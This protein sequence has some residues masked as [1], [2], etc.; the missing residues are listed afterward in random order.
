MTTIKK[1]IFVAI[2][3]IGIILMIVLFTSSTKKSFEC[4][5]GTFSD[6]GVTKC[7]Y[8]P[9]GKYSSTPKSTT[10]DDCPAGQYSNKGSDTC[11][12]CPAGQYASSSGSPEC[13]QCDAGSISRGGVVF[14]CDDCP[15]GQS[16]NKGSM[17]CTDCPAGKSSINGGLCTDCPAGKY[18]VKAGLCTDCPAGKYASS[19]GS[20]VC[21]NCPAGQYSDKGSNVCTKC[22]KGKYS[23]EG[24]SGCLGCPRGTHG[25]KL[26]A[27]S[28]T[29]GCIKCD[30][31]GYQ[32]ETG[33]PECKM[34]SD[35]GRG[36]TFSHGSDNANDCSTCKRG[37]R[38]V[39]GLCQKCILDGYYSP[40]AGL[41]EKCPKD[42]YSVMDNSF[43]IK[44]TLECIDCPDGW[45]TNGEVGQKYCQE[46][47]KE[48]QTIC[49]P[50]PDGTISLD[51]DQSSSTSIFKPRTN[52][53]LKTAIKLHKTDK[54]ASDKLYREIGS[55]NVSNITDMTYLFNDYASFNEDISN[56]D[57]SNVTKMNGMF[58]GPW[59]SAIDQ[60]H[61]FRQDISTWNVVNL[62]NAYAMFANSQFNKPLVG[63]KNKIGKLEN[64]GWMFLNSEFNQDLSSWSTNPAFGTAPRFNTN[65]MTLESKM[66]A[67]N[68]KKITDTWH[69]CDT[70]EAG[71]WSTTW[72]AANPE[73]I[74]SYEGSNE[75]CPKN[76]CNKDDAVPWQV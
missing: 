40:A 22:P 74:S 8:C 43:D 75:S 24:M 13:T 32:D 64:L 18:S 35:L 14:K 67:A 3:V 47:F 28:E 42:T 33:Q 25:T 66:S 26:G 61:A 60:K 48:N 72:N 9:A 49:T 45:G 71:I 30:Y 46:I 11:N 39:T 10:C 54:Q 2:I 41:C 76:C 69:W 6:D 38:L 29:D 50:K 51:C 44:P 59:T 7:E 20:T 19:S 23:S 53:A 5:V 17:I 27:V 21:S 63:W 57:V 55:W 73:G 52:D 1:M 56:W 16:S 31:K 36:N 15:A 70:R 4:P 62:Q 68:L 34:C 58:M 65:M 37:E 12:N